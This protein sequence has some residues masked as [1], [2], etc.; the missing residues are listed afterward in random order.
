[1]VTNL[2]SIL[3]N[4]Y[5]S[6]SNAFSN[7]YIILIV[8]I[9]VGYIQSLIVSS[10]L[11]SKLTLLQENG[12]IKPNINIKVSKKN[13]HPKIFIDDKEHFNGNNKPIFKQKIKKPKSEHFTQ[14]KDDLEEF[15]SKKKRKK[16]K[17]KENF[18]SNKMVDRNFK[19]LE[20]NLPYEAYNNEDNCYTNLNYKE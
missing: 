5:N 7:I 2:K 3:L 14:E 13:N 6:L 15:K 20:N 10:M 9:V 19:P 16:I 8:V 11:D 1:M 12:I 4:F 18:I 17:K